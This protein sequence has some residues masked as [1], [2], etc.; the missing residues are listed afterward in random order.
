[1]QLQLPAAEIDARKPT[2]LPTEY[3]DSP[4][5]EVFYDTELNPN[6]QWR[7]QA[8]DPDFDTGVLVD[9]TKPVPFMAIM[10]AVA[11]Q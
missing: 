5:G 8:G 10:R 4:D 2:A 6:W 3:K 11:D 7:R 9:P 1:M